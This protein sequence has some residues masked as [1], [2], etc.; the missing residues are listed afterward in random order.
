MTIKKCSSLSAYVNKIEQIYSERGLDDV[1]L[2]RGHSN[3]KYLLLPAAFRDGVVDEFSECHKIEIEYPEEFNKRDHLSSLAKMQ[4]YGV[5]TRLLDFTRNPLVALYFAV[6]ENQDKDGAI[7][8]IKNKANKIKHHSS[9]TVLCLACLSFLTKDDQTELLKYCLNHRGKKL[10]K[11]AYQTNR[12][13]HHLYHEIRSQY[14]TFEFEINVDDLLSNFFVAVNKN[15]DRLKAQDGLFAICGLDKEKTSEQFDDQVY[16]K[17]IIP[18]DRKKGI[19][20][21]LDKF[22]VKDSTIYPSLDRVAL[23]LYGKHF[24]S[25]TIN[26]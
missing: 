6:C 9:D 15:S 1:V 21:L 25:E 4:H 8:V 11:F 5:K 26:K 3:N 23:N 24:I 18:K 10:G 20:N 7:I 12:A 2:F 14:P 13:V 16:A 17:L 19:V 22:G